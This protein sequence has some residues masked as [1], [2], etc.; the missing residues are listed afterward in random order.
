MTDDASLYLPDSADLIRFADQ[1]IW[2]LH[3]DRQLAETYRG[4]ALQLKASLDRENTLGLGQCARVRRYDDGTVIEVRK[5][6]NFYHLHIACPSKQQAPAVESPPLVPQLRT[7][8]FFYVPGCSSRFDFFNPKAYM[9]NEIPLHLKGSFTD[10]A[11]YNEGVVGGFLTPAQAGLPAPGT[12]PD[13]SISRRYGCLQFMGSSL[14]DADG[15]HRL[16][17]GSAN[18][19]V[20]GPFTISCLFRLHAAVEYDYSQT[21]QTNVLGNG[22]TVN[23]VVKPRLLFSNDG[24]A[25]NAKCPGGIAPLMAY[26]I[27]SRFSRHWVRLTYPWNP[28]NQDFVS[29]AQSQIGYVELESIC[30]GAPLLATDYDADSPYWDKI[31]S[32]GLEALT[33]DVDAVWALND[34][35]NNTAPYMA[36]CRFVVQ[37]SHE[38]SVGT[39]V[40]R[41]LDDG[42]LRYA[43][44]FSSSYDAEADKT[45][46]VLQDWLHKQPI[47]NGGETA[48]MRFGLQP[49]PLNNPYG[50]VIGFNFQGLCFLNDGAMRLAAG[51]IAD[52]END[53]DTPPIL[54]APLSLGSWHHAVLTCSKEGLC[55]LYLVE[56][57]S[58]T[59][60]VQAAWQS[61]QSFSNEDGFGIKQK[62]AAG[63]MNWAQTPS[64]DSPESDETAEWEYAC[65]MDL[66]LLRFYH[67][68]LSAAECQLLTMEVFDGVFVA[69]DHE[70]GQLAGAGYTPITV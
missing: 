15:G 65:Q 30:P 24:V 32:G 10:D 50:V 11:I 13:G 35:L 52:F 27:P 25:W 70:A 4:A 20:D 1:D 38:K 47:G 9:R 43:T 3:G 58:K 21:C 14:D 62:I 6:S 23:N 33:G 54:S 63:A 8:Q 31:V 22:Y 40:S 55:K 12:S 17:L 39:R 36:F 7:G 37:G 67:R 28:Y 53:Y 45:T 16:E 29:S 68:E 18:L 2:F 49:F 19:P 61:A 60:A 66:G 57:G 44:V 42:T 26:A 46:L 41:S 69:D 64:P 51:R 59:I 48:L 5:L 56:Q 34:T